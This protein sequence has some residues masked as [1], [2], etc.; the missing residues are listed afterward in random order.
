MRA[1]RLVVKRSGTR[2]T[3][4]LSL[5]AV[6]AIAAF[7]LCGMAGY[8]AGTADSAV[9]ET[10]TSGPAKSAAVQLSTRLA[11]DNGQQADAVQ[12][13]IDDAFTDAE[14]ATYRTVRT[15]PAAASVDGQA[16]ELILL[17]DPGIAEH[18]TLVDG[19]WPG[20]NPGTGATPAA[21]QATAA[22][23]LGLEVGDLFTVEGFEF[24]LA[25]TWL[26][27]DPTDPYWF[28][29]PAA[30]S[31][32]DHLSRGPVVTAEAVL[33]EL[34]V[35]SYARWT[36]VPTNSALTADRMPALAGALDRLALGV[37]RADTEQDIELA[38]SLG[39]RVDQVQRSLG[40]AGALVT[41][42]AVLVGVIGLITLTQLARLLVAVRRTETALLR[43]RGASVTQLALVSLVEALAVILPGVAVGAVAV[44]A[45]LGSGLIPVNAAAMAETIWPTALAVAAVAALVCGVV[46]WRAALAGAG[47][48]Q[49][50]TGRA[51][52][53]VTLG[54]TVL[55]LV[56][57]GVSLWQ[58]K[59]YGSP[60]VTSQDGAIRV[61]PLTVIAP[62]LVLLALAMLGLLAF[63]PAAR[64]VERWAARS[65][66]ILPLLPVRQVARRAP[67]FGV[68]L[69][70]ITLS[71]SGTTLT[72]FYSH[73]WA[74]ASATAA[75]LANGADVR[76][77][78]SPAPTVEG[79][80]A[81]VS[82]MPY[83]RLPGVD[84]AATV[85][86]TPVRIADDSVGL[87]AMAAV[88]MPGVMQAVD[89][90]VDPAQLAS[91]L[92]VEPTGVPLEGDDLQ[93]TVQVSAEPGQE[94]GQVELFA[95]LE[96]TDGSL[97][98]LSLGSTAVAETAPKTLTAALPEARS[99]GWTMLAVE[100]VLSS[101]EGARGVQAT[102]TGPDQEYALTVSSTEPSD[103]AVTYPEL[104][105]LPVVVTDALAARL[106]LQAGSSLSARIPSTAS[107]VE[108]MVVGLTAAIP[109]AAGT[110][111]LVAD[112]PTLNRYL[113]STSER[114]PQAS[115][116]WLST[117][118]GADLIEPA[119]TAS[120][121]SATVTA[122][123]DGSGERVIAPALVAL[124]WGT[125]GALL[126]AA[127]A[128]LAITNTFAQDRRDEVVVLRALGL[129]PSEQGRNRLVEMAS[130]AG[131][132]M[133]TGVV[134][135]LIASA[136][137]VT[138][139]ATTAAGSSV[140]V[141]L[142]FDVLGWVTLV[143]ALLTLVV[144]ILTSYAATVARQA[145]DT[146]H[147][148]EAR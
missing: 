82:A 43:A 18:A 120:V 11:A 104:A 129:S 63:G 77:R 5:F 119:V 96:D 2:S 68:A 19:E 12:V 31:G 53:S 89:G 134:G 109:T 70:L 9:R 46:S 107:A 35:R 105:T 21:V 72:A 80:A 49:G 33:A 7:L 73:T 79:S 115:E 130:V 54:A 125:A 114:I 26:P 10:L 60:L 108:A 102:V 113:L 141:S 66:G 138:E 145:R 34:P 58:F 100:T 144:T 55:V 118:P 117:E 112:L 22:E 45:L 101:A 42:P 132:A 90:S 139:L 27:V 41:V 59:L 99:G 30:A 56:A 91:A 8:L 111:G 71:V 51:R 131:A 106:S 85:L 122:L 37:E 67:V 6:V 29:D 24:A 121:T 62:A 81:L 135:G 93:L 136:L 36:I 13:L 146:E 97:A 110:L 124:W 123:G 76:V 92:D 57:A 61:D 17:A 28:A 38:G 78:L 148:G 65:H 25:A 75:Q 64:L 127:I 126:L 128:V 44:T 48:A 47:P 103:R 4:L 147:R 142:R 32:S 52:T 98:L 95:W 83:L 87:T 74:G 39:E 84:D 140:P 15:N 3:L 16:T 86:R 14:V 20:P 143:F 69:L 137:T 50:E 1:A 23:Q 133:L 88:R 94:A 40:V 116:V